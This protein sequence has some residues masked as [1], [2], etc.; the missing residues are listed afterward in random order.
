M[1]VEKK[2]YLL[3]TPYGGHV[4]S[5]IEMVDQG[6]VTL[7]SHDVVFE[8]EDRDENQIAIMGLEHLLKAEQAETEVKQQRIKNRIA[9]LKCITHK[10][11]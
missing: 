10:S 3:A 9:E 11:E 5:Q 8:F 4:C 2:V 1:K 6:Y 7:A